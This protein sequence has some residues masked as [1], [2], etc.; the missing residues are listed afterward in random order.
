MDDR[1]RTKPDDIAGRTDQRRETIAMSLNGAS[2]KIEMSE[3]ELRVK[4]ILA[5]N[6]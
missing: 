5:S 4:H 3:N 6:S 2:E 1:A